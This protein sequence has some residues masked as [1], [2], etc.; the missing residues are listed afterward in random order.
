MSPALLRRIAAI[1]LLSACAAPDPVAPPLP[2]GGITALADRDP[3]PM[4]FVADL[5]AREAPIALPDGT[6]VAGLGYEGRVPGPLIRVPLGASIDV[7]LH[8]ELPDGIHTGIHWHGIEGVNASDGTPVTQAAV[9]PHGAFDYRFTATRA[10]FYWY[11]PHVDGSQRVF[12]GLYAPLLVDDPDEGALVDAGVLPRHEQILVLSDLSQYDGRILRVADDGTDVMN[13]TEG[14]VMLV[15]GMVAPTIPIPA[16]EPTRLRVVNTSIARFWRLSVP[17]HVLYRIGGEG[18]LLDQ[19]RVEGGAVPA[20]VTALADGASIG[21]TEYDLGYERGEILLAP[22]ERADLVLQPI[23]DPGDTLSLRWE[24]YARGRHQMWV[25]DGEVRMGDADDDGTRPGVTV[26]TFALVDGA[27][28][29]DPGAPWALD[30]GDPILGVV[31]RS[32]GPVADPADP[33]R[34]L[35]WTG[36][37]AMVLSEEMDHVQDATGAWQMTSAFY[38]DGASWM[39]DHDAGPEQPLAPTAARARLGDVVSWEIRND[40]EMAHPIHLHG[41]SYAPVALTSDDLVAG[42]RTTVPFG[43]DSFDDT[44]LIPGRTSLWIRMPL[45]DPLGDGSA[46]GRW[47]RHCH[48]LQHGE[49][50]MMSELVVDR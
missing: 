35:D 2:T 22:A 33:S 30:E 20:T 18:G 44:T 11:H 6:I 47:M 49:N 19:V 16:G 40:S 7:T 3:D 26:A 39:P 41:F 21:T 8:N 38:L 12:E 46:A 34:L 48:L 32:V 13:G 36:P 42:T 9:E 1:A 10:G 5:T 24:D 25:E 15:N 31:G 37:A 14:D 28:G 45:A 27:D 29:A 50:G 23:G 17:G 4:R 43:Y